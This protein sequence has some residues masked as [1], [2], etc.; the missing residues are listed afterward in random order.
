MLARRSVGLIF[1]VVSLA[2][3]LCAQR[4]ALTQPR[5]LA[6]LVEQ[7]ALIVRG[8]VLSARTEP[9]PQFHNLM[10]VVVTLRVTE[11]LKGEPAAT[12]TYRQFIW[13]IRNRM[14]AAGYGK[15]QELLLLM[16]A[17]TRYG[18]SSPAGLE[19]GRFR[20]RRGAQG[21]RVAMNGVGNAGL[22]RDVES[23]LK[24][25]RRELPARLLPLVREHRYGPLRADDLEDLVRQLSRTPTR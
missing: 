23:Q 19:Q 24:R 13:D 21:N 25:Q 12:L 11:T 9:H 16:N 1:V 20:V 2:A 7:S 4:G 15:G 14:D 17:P 18:F 6:Q 3:P 8:Q 10:T 5:N 22:F